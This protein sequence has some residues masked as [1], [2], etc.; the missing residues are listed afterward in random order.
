MLGFPR[1]SPSWYS[2][3][4]IQ[5]KRD[6]TNG[7]M[8]QTKTRQGHE[9]DRRAL[10]RISTGSNPVGLGQWSLQPPGMALPGSEYMEGSNEHRALAP[11]WL[12][13][14]FLAELFM[15]LGPSRHQ[16]P[17]SQGSRFLSSLWKPLSRFCF[18]Y[19]TSP[20]MW[21]LALLRS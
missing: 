5:G 9:R 14:F 2:I 12:A 20:R 8:G 7:N 13:V 10:P 11:L 18:S 19:Q 17:T 21:D 15:K 6:R 16:L 1:T 4:V 3:V